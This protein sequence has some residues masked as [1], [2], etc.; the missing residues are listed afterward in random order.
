MQQRYLDGKFIEVNTVPPIEFKEMEFVEEDEILY[1][2]Q[3]FLNAH[4]VKKPKQL[5]RE[6][7]GEIDAAFLE[8]LPYA[9]EHSLTRGY[10]VFSYLNDYFVYHPNFRGTIYRIDSNEVYPD[11]TMSFPGP[12]TSEEVMRSDYVKRKF[13]YMR[14]NNIPWITN[15]GVDDNQIIVCYKKR[16][17]NFVARLSRENNVWDVNHEHLRSNGHVF[18]APLKY[19]NGYLMWI[20]PNYKVEHYGKIPEG[21]KKVAKEWEEELDRLNEAYD[22]LGAKT[23][24]LL[25]LKEYLPVRKQ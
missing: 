18:P 8:P 6:K 1:A 4:V 20:I 10:D 14:E 25:K 22:G 2:C 15:I 7:R 13:S 16:H 17:Q 3:G 12:E 19:D 21:A 11:F 5:I 24:F 23:L 9:P